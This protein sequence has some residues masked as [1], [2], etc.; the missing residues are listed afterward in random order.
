MPQAFDPS[1]VESIG[2]YPVQRYVAEGGMSWIFEVR[3]PSF[4]DVDVRRALKLLKPHAAIGAELQRFMDEVSILATVDHPNLIRV[5][6]QGQ[7]EATGYHFFVMELLEGPDLSQVQAEWLGDPEATLQRGVLPSYEDICGYFLGVLSALSAVHARDIFHRD[8]KPQNIALTAGGIAKLFDFGIAKEVGSAGVTQQGMVPGTPLYMSPEQS[9]GEPVG[10]ASDLFS[11]GLTMYRVLTGLT[12][13]QVMLGSDTTTQMVLRHL[14]TLHGSGEEFQFEFLDVIPEGVREVIRRAC[15]VKPEERYADA[16][17]MRA[18]LEQALAPAAPLPPTQ[19]RPGELPP[20]MRRTAI[21]LAAALVLGAGGFY[22]A[23]RFQDDRRR[24]EVAR[25]QERAVASQSQV[26][27]ILAW[28]EE[29]DAAG[30]KSLL[31]DVRADLRTVDED[32]TDGAQ[33]LQ[34]GLWDRSQR[35]FERARSGYAALCDRLSNQYLSA[36]AETRVKQVLDAVGGV[37][38]AASE[39]VPEAYNAL[40]ASGAKLREKIESAGCERASGLQ[41]RL[42]SADEAIARAREVTRQLSEYWPKLVAETVGTAIAAKLAA[43]EAAVELAAYA[44]EVSDAQAQ[45][46][47][48]KRAQ[49]RKGWEQANAAAELATA[50]F[51]RAAAIGP[52]HRAR[53]AA[54]KLVEAA[55]RDGISIGA[56][57]LPYDA[58][59]EAFE[60]GNWAEANDILSELTPQFEQ[61]L[62]QAAPAIEACKLARQAR[63]SARAAGVPEA[64]LGELD[65]RLEDA[66][67]K[68]E[69]RRFD[70]VSEGCKQLV[71]DFGRKEENLAQEI[72][73]A[74]VEREEERRRKQQEEEER[75]ARLQ[76]ELEQ[77]EREEAQA[78][79]RAERER[80]Q[81]LARQKAELE[82]EQRAIEEEQKLRLRAEK[83]REAEK[84][85]AQAADQRARQLLKQLAERELPTRAFDR[86][87]GPLRQALQEG[88][89]KD[90]EPGLSSLA[91]QMDALLQDSE[92]VVAA[93]TDARAARAGARA[94]GVSD[95]DL[96]RADELLADASRELGQGRLDAATRAFEAARREFQAA[97]ASHQARLEELAR[98]KREEERLARIEA[99]KR[100]ETLR[101]AKASADIA[102]RDAREQVAALEGRGLPLGPLRQSFDSARRAYQ[103]D[104]EQGYAEA[105]RGF[106]QVAAGGKQRLSDAVPALEALASAQAA[107]DRALKRGARGQRLQRAESVLKAGQAELAAGRFGGAAEKFSSAVVAFDNSG[108]DPKELVARVMEEWN[109]AWNERDLALLRAT[110]QL[111][112]KQEQGYDRY[113]KS[114]DEIQQ[115]LANIR[116][117]RT[118]KSSF[119]VRFEYSRTTRKGASRKNRPKETRLAKVNRV[120]GSW[121][122]TDLGK[123]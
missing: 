27:E 97:Q 87:M 106:R 33:D 85:L 30:T 17:E 74:E 50:G 90:A 95:P 91:D 100:R 40:Q 61:L 64:S 53:E 109:R 14:W 88:R 81:E 60:A 107:R 101:K 55:E 71:V 42:H 3:D 36:A 10:A 18:A 43:D 110:Q 72:A 51:Q 58:G 1:A 77:K 120:N 23:K 11:L 115:Q 2:G 112:P 66:Q 26:G 113:F 5:Y 24:D 114:Y 70:I 63:A 93:R 82:A 73:Q 48:A 89:W 79:A 13:Y 86:D 111:S 99:E 29:N 19:P 98:Q 105:E 117:E 118:G 31:E 4:V 7:D 9:L 121:I 8:I 84:K 56:L 32:L 108:P 104:D 80:E 45:L 116:I 96:E 68:F 22:L 94:D 34:D 41:A 119:E 46:D 83:E 75:A 62:A 47:L 78:A 69:A 15:R 102:R 38:E 52:A 21:G 35:G 37:P 6:A 103:R 65:A 20:W 123:P 67:R 39:R 16:A 76:A 54:E 59:R 25:I 12:V 122:I 49:E 92:R 28:L 57:R 44:E